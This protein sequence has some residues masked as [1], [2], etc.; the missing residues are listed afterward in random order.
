MGMFV[1]GPRLCGGKQKPAAY[2]AGFMFW[3][4][5]QDFRCSALP[6]LR[7]LHFVPTEPLVISPKGELTSF[8]STAPASK[9]NKAA[10][11][12]GLVHFGCGARI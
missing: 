5:G 12:G 7:G 3:L 10:R 11:M 1:L 9:M 2:A 6:A 8:S 4:R